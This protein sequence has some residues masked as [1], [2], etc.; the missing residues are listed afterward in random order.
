MHVRLLLRQTHLTCLSSA[1]QTEKLRK[2]T[3]PPPPLTPPCR[4][5]ERIIT[6]GITGYPT[7]ALPSTGRYCA[8]TS[9]ACWQYKWRVPCAWASYESDAS[10]KTRC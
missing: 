9:C 10:E 6:L 3:S 7:D 4:H 1:S 8:T 2:K 5:V